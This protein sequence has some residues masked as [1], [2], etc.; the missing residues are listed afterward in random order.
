MNFIPFRE[1]SQQ[2]L[3]HPA[4]FTTTYYLLPTTY[5]LL[6]THYYL[7]PVHRSLLTINYANPLPLPLHRTGH[8]YLII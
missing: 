7:L 8:T 6:P 4:W 1:S 5:Y 3:F 2:D